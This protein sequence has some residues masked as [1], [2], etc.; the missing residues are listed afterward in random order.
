MLVR[1]GCSF[2]ENQ[3]MLSKAGGFAKLAVS[4]R[5]SVPVLSSIIISQEGY[6]NVRGAHLGEVDRVCTP[7][8]CG[9]VFEEENIE[10]P[11]Q[12]GIIPEVGLKRLPFVLHLLLHG[13]DEYL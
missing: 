10:E 1:I 6:I 13:T 2:D 9:K 12:Q 3:A 5:E 7:V 4:G 8:G 11:A